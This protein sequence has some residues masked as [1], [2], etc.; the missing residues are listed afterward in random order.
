MPFKKSTFKFNKIYILESLPNIEKQTG[1]E[2]Y[3]DLLRYKEYE[4][5]ALSVVFNEIIDK[6]NFFIILKK[7][8]LDCRKNKNKPILHIEMH[9]NEAKTGL[10]FKNGEIVTWEELYN[11]LVTINF[12]VE[13]NLFLTLAV[14]YGL[15][16][17]Q[18]IQLDKPA[19]FWGFIGSYEEITVS[20]LSIRYNEFYSSFLKD[21]KLY[22]SMV[23]LHNSNPEIQS[24]YKL[25]T[26]EEVFSNVYKKYLNENFNEKAIDKRVEDSIKVSGILFDNR[27]IKRKFRKD[28]EKLLL[29][30][31]KEYFNEHKRIFFMIKAYPQNED[32]FKIDVKF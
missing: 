7:I 30:T 16:I 15:Y 21:F 27:N 11:S 4:I 1:R 8:E 10:V 3:D 14:C 22:E 28:F 29:K 9:G 19:P 6:K 20:D 17:M 25:I 12:A 26:S 31:K 13:N 2:L 24:T 18:I 5:S 23:A 32:R